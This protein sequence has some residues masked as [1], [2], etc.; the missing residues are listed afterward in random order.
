M[1]NHD[2]EERT[3]P[4]NHLGYCILWPVD[5]FET[6]STGFYST[7]QKIAKNYIPNKHSDATNLKN[8]TWSNYWFS[9]Y[10]QGPEI[11]VMGNMNF[12]S[13]NLKVS[14]A[15]VYSVVIRGE[16][17]KSDRIVYKIEEI[18]NG[19]YYRISLIQ[20]GTESEEILTVS[21]PNSGGSV[22]T[23]NLKLKTINNLPKRLTAKYNPS[24]GVYIIDGFV[25]SVFKQIPSLSFSENQKFDNLIEA[26]GNYSKF[27]PYTNTHN[28]FKFNIKVDIYDKPSDII[29]LKIT[30]EKKV[31]EDDNEIDFNGTEF[32]IGSIIEQTQ[33]IDSYFNGQR[34]ETSITVI[35]R[36]KSWDK[37]SGELVVH[38]SEEQTQ[39][40]QEYNINGY[41]ISGITKS[42]IDQSEKSSE[43]L[44]RE[45]NPEFDSI[46]NLNQFFDCKEFTSDEYEKY[47]EGR[48][49]DEPRI[50]FLSS[51]PFTKSNI[52][53]SQGISRESV[54]LDSKTE[55]IIVY[56]SINELRD[57]F[58]DSYANERY[59]SEINSG[60]SK[61]E[62][63]DFVVHEDGD[64]DFKMYYVPEQDKFMTGPEYL[65]Y[66]YKEG[67]IKR[68][69]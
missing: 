64:V 69:L 49:K 51:L 46:S 52:L 26:G 43:E 53:Q 65:N 14:L 21:R 33:T 19:V 13:G 57:F 17:S 25:E 28:V 12:S 63:Y 44:F 50:D 10:S 27:V 67:Y 59:M 11:T 34:I 16:T 1:S 8:D 37:D 66:L 45:S 41:E 29:E 15:K 5:F 55:R 62:D 56:A 20:E 58:I 7:T 18:N 61:P 2:E 31:D 24:T 54:G 23:N 36:V 48:P 68:F 9:R 38:Q 30:I 4:W 60:I 35:G 40:S 39:I 47:M 42:I 22:T 3:Y 32:T 6:R